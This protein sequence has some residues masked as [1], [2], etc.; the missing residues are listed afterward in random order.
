MPI[1]TSIIMK[2]CFKYFGGVDRC[3]PLR[4]SL[5]QKPDTSV[6]GSTKINNKTIHIVV[7]F[8]IVFVIKVGLFLTVIRV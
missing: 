6:N 4:C 1:N 8:V 2:N 3:L 7:V 5:K